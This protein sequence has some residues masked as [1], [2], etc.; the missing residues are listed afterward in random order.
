[1]P[2]E[3]ARLQPPAYGPLSPRCCA[4]NS[5]TDRRVQSAE[6]LHSG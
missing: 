6:E 1:M 3:V 5:L 2:D 4:K